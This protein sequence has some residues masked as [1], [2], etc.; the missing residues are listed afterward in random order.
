MAFK[1]G[2]VSGFA[3]GYYLG[4]KAGRQRYEQ[5]NQA[6]SKLRRSDA[7][8]SA[9]EKAKTVVGEKVESAKNLVESKVGNGKGDETANVETANVPPPPPRFN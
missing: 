1:V 3:A 2:L 9:T 6:L 8:D 5:M 7:V 4:A